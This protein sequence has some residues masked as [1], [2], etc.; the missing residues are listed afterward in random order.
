M[1]VWHGHEFDT[2][3]P[4]ETEQMQDTREW[5]FGEAAKSRDCFFC[6]EFLSFPLVYWHGYGPADQ[7]GDYLFL[8]GG[9]AERLA[10]KLIGDAEA[11]RLNRK[12]P[13]NK[14]RDDG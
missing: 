14:G 10:V 7:S 8:H 11:L 2:T 6:G 4:L 5:Q 3:D 9:C 12:G 13:G 1:G